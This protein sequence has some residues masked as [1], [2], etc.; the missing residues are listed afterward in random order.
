MTAIRMAKYRRHAAL[1]SC[2]DAD[3]LLHVIY[4]CVALPGSRVSNNVAV[5][6]WRG[7]R[8]GVEVGGCGIAGNGLRRGSRRRAAMRN[9]ETAPLLKLCSLR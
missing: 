8:S 6:G 1:D 4:L 9:D 3:I 5:G 2:L 7:R